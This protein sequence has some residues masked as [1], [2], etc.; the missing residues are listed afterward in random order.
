MSMKSFFIIDKLGEIIIERHFL[1][2]VSR[3]VAEQFYTE[4]MKENNQQETNNNSTS[5]IS[6]ILTT[7]KYYIIHIYRHSLYFVGIVDR[8]SQPLLVIE[9]LHRIVDIL[10]TYI[11]KV[12][13]ANI[14]NHFVTIYQLLDEM[15]DGGFPITTEIALLKDLVRQPSS[16]AQLVSNV[17]KSNNNSVG[18]TGHNKSIVPW[19]KA[20]IKYVNNEI[21][22]DII[23]TLNVIVDVNGGSAISEVVGTIK[24]NCKLSGTPDL[25]LQF[26]DPGIIEDI[27]FHPCVRYARYEQD[28]SI[29][30]IP[31]DGEY[32]LLSYRMSNLPMLPI[33][34]R[35]QLTFY[36]GGVNV[37][38]M[39]GLRHTH[40]KSLDNVKVF[41][42]MPNWESNQ[43]QATVGN[44]QYDAVNHR[45]VWNV[46]KL[47]PQTQQSKA[48]APSLT[49]KINFMNGRGEK[50][51][52]P[53]VQLQFELDG[54]CVSGLKV[55]S[56]QLRNE[57]Y[58]PFK[59]VRYIT[60]AGRYE[61]RTV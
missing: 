52:C 7:S 13:E 18:I 42:S 49:G 37:N 10:E 31:P 34:C 4:V 15:I 6:P 8:E 57:N 19:R 48:P 56:V 60:N 24:S 45:L 3:S 12:N 41:V 40:N 11:D 30:F 51:G 9:L 44:I 5:N 39:L 38:I 25:L 61:V 36:K 20:G 47:S 46:G 33:Y 14:K 2:K 22:F 53:A 17:G 50:D 29:S 59:G 32:E 54:V 58:K 43:L 55:E 28:K 21:Y 1:G 35:P 23:E 16:L 27:S 26:N